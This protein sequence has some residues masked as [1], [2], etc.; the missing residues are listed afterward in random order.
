MTDMSICLHA[1]ANA[2]LPHGDGQKDKK[3]YAPEETN[4]TRN[5]YRAR[6]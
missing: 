6:K 2:E 1:T 5:G 3:R 4:P